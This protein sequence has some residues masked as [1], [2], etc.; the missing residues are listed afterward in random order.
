MCVTDIDIMLDDART[1]RI[2]AV[3]REYDADGNERVVQIKRAYILP[4][5]ADPDSMR[6]DFEMP[7]LLIVIHKMPD[8]IGKKKPRLD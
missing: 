3:R 6:A 1:L 2:S 4:K 5:Y 7:N 8:L